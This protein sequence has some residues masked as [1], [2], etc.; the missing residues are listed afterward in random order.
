MATVTE[1]KITKA[2]KNSAIAKLLID[3]FDPN[4]M[5]YA[6]PDQKISVG[7]LL[8]HLEHENDLLAK[9][10]KSGSSGKM[11]KAQE[12]HLALAKELG[13]Y[14][15]GEPSRLFTIT[16]LSKEAPCVAGFN[17]Q[18]I[19]PLLGKL[20]EMGVVINTRE[21]GKSFFQCAPVPMT[22]EEYA[23]EEED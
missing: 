11:T 10:S 6:T 4:E 2:Q 14:M 20:M 12:E 18:K 9:K 8:A 7:E 1:K 17:P 16:E 3:S 21:K 5:V 22:D 13:E 15:A 23:E 19:R